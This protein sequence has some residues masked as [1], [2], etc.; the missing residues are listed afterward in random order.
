Q[1]S[2]KAPSITDENIIDYVNYETIE[3]SGLLVISTNKDLGF[4]ASLKQYPKPRIILTPSIPAFAELEEHAA[5]DRIYL[6]NVEIVK[7]KTAAIPPTLDKYFYPVKYISVELARE[8]PFDFYSNK[9]EINS[10]LLSAM[11]TIVIEK[12]TLG[13]YITD[14]ID[15]PLNLIA[16]GGFRS[17]W[18]FYRFDQQAVLQ[19]LNEKRPFEYAYEAG[20]TYKYNERSSVY[21]NISRSFRFPAI[22]EWYSS[23]YIDYF[24][25]LIAG[26]LN[27][28][29]KPQ[30]AQTY[31]VGIK[32][33][34]SKYLDLK[35]DYYISDLK[36]ELYYDAVTNQNS[37]YHHTIHHGLELEGRA[38]IL[39]SIRAFA[40]YTYEK[41]FFV[42][43]TFAGNT[44]P[45]VPRH[46][47]SVGFEYTLADC[48]RFQYAANYVGTQW[49][50]ND[51]QNNMP[52]MKQYLTH[53]IKMSYQKH[54]FEVFGVINN[55][56]NADY[57]EFSV[58][59]WSL[60]RPGYYPA[61][62]RNFSVGVNYKF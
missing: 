10:G 55:V 40:N 13:L 14:T 33:G 5:L 3:G 11:D 57:S 32:E 4:K 30:I 19:S 53:D 34:S 39:D 22:D 41:A 27:L 49:F 58:L 38:F 6:N 20:L 43:G 7:D 35:A 37:V 29:L 21:A 31:E 8:L 12:D 2:P 59:D 18:A 62:R 56:L 47:L 50:V 23:L 36:N 46:K 24:S 26:G 52:K 48:F 42:G 28:N 25:G 45:L 51:L 54:G 15:L 1:V 17:E 9:D 61:P 60:T 44:I 16:N